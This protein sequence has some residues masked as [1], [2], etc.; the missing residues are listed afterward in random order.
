MDVPQTPLLKRQLTKTF[1]LA[2]ETK[3]MTASWTIL[4]ISKKVLEVDVL[5]KFEKEVEYK[6][7]PLLPTGRHSCQHT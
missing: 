3:R 6:T 5:S 2:L 1:T 7:V 4:L